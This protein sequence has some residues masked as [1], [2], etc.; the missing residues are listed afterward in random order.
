MPQL[1]KGS[2]DEIIDVLQVIS[3]SA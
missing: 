2:D 1:I 3:C